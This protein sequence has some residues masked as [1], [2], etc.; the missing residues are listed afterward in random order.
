MSILDDETLKEVGRYVI[1]FT[2]LDELITAL[3]AAVLECAEWDIGKHLTGHLTVGR[4]L[5]GIQ[6]VCHI[7]AKAHGLLDTRLLKTLL[8][9]IALAREIIDKRNAVIHGELTIKHGK[10]PTVRSKTATVELGPNDLSVLVQQINRA[11]DGLVAAYYDFMDAVYQA[12]A[13][14]KQH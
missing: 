2:T 11:T 8:G 4:K 3:A 6:K 10:R 9:K 1:E 13:A 12:R 7:L 5:D 14:G